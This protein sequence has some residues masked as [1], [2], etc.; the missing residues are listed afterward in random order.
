[1]R[2]SRLDAQAVDA[3]LE[4][5][6][7]RVP[8]RR[9]WPAGLTTREVEVLRLLTQGRSNCAIAA[10]LCISEKTVRNHVEHIYAKLGVS[11]R[12]GA[13]LF[14]IEHGIAG[15]SPNPAD[16]RWGSSPMT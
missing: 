9:V 16:E 7:Q 5:A 3:V 2:E 12:T 6:G 4:A 1:M 10:E 11:N 14:A 15:N 13:S 8:R